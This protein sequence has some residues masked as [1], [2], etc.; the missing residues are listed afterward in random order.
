MLQQAHVLGGHGVPGAGHG[1]D[2]IQQVTL[3]LFDAAEVGDDLARLHDDLT[4]QQAGRAYNFA[5][6]AHH[7]HQRVHLGEVA[8]VGAELLPDIGHR[9]KADDIHALIAEVKHVLRHVVKHDGVCIVQVPLIGVE[10]GH[11]HLAR[12]ITPAEVAGCG[13]GEDLGHGLFKLA[14][15]VPAVVEEVSVLK[16]LLAGPCTLCPF[17]VLTGVV[18][19]EVE[20]DGDITAVAVGGEGGQILHR[21]ERGLDLAEVRHRVAAV[22]AAHGA[23]QQGHQVQIVD[24][25]LLNV[26]ELFAHAFE[27]TGKAVHIHQHADKVVALVP[28]RVCE[29]EPVDLA[30]ILAALVICALE[31]ADKIVIGLLIVV[32]ELHE[33]PAQLLLMV[34]KA[35]LKFARPS[36]FIHGSSLRCLIC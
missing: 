16:L 20:A 32:V 22:A 31:H 29:F 10:G 11:D 4:Q 2:V 27:C 13:G 28:V 18:H 30:Q 36:L 26:I 9:V 24:A 14:G 34:L 25:A 7:A 15:N 17:V 5:H 23:F 33:E 1:G 12:L 35:G 6:H 3:G 8:A 21:A 19:H